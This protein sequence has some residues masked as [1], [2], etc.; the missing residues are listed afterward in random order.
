MCDVGT[1][2]EVTRAAKG[3][4]ENSWRR[5]QEAIYGAGL[6]S[7]VRVP[8]CPIIFTSL[9]ANAPTGDSKYGRKEKKKH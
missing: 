6:G 9:A 4:P 7:T 5:E 8:L 3:G 1:P 2:T